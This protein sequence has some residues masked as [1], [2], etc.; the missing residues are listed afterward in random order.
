MRYAR[1]VLDWLLAAKLN[2]GEMQ[3]DCYR[4]DVLS[5]ISIPS[6]TMRGPSSFAVVVREA[7]VGSKHRR[8][9]KMLL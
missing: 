9:T 6:T 5:G 8:D 7:L 4:F 1:R 2:M 3:M